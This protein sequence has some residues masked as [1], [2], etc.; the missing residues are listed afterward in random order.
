MINI[1]SGSKKKG[2]IKTIATD[3]ARLVVLSGSKEIKKELDSLKKRVEEL[4]AEKVS[5]E[6][7][8]EWTRSYK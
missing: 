4:E 2:L 5:R 1:I 3:V 7:M 8:K 6:E